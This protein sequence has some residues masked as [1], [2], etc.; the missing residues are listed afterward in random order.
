MSL[1]QGLFYLLD[2]YG[3]GSQDGRLLRHAARRP[4][5]RLFEQRVEL[6]VGSR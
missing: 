1:C 5:N 6:T 3:R 2:A 4:R